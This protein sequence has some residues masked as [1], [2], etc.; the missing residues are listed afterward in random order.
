[1]QTIEQFISYL[2]ADK[3]Y[4]NATALTYRMSLTDLWRFCRRIDEQIT[5]ANL[6]KDVLRRWMASDIEKGTTA[7]TVNRKMSSVRSFYRYLLRMELVSVDP[8]ATLKNP[9][10]ERRLPT[11]L[12]EQDMNR[13][14]DEVE[15]GEG[16]EAER[17]RLILLTFYSTGIRLSEL[18]GLKVGSVDLS[19]KELK[20]LGK[21]NKHRVIPFGGEL[22]EAFASFFATRRAEV[23]QD[24]GE[25][26]LRADG[27][28]MTPA[29]V[30]AVVKKYLSYV[31][32]QQKRSPHVLRHT[33]AT[34][35]LNNGADLE[36]VKELLGHESVATTEVY[37]HTTFAELKKAYE[38]AH[39]RA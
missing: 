13:L 12:N 35:M 4:S 16:Y 3:G 1:M 38:K 28:V 5:W 30:R 34:V 29:E 14:F 2:L 10:I 6:D 18:L 15:F 31:T 27:K 17:N 39:P 22:A 36:A 7:R 24:V 20:V 9:K 8:T 11:F 32:R 19:A 33:Y 23:R 26:F 37:T 21:R 25:I